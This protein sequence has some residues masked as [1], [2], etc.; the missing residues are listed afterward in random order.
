MDSSFRVIQDDTDERYQVFT[1]ISAINE[2]IQMDNGMGDRRMMGR[3]VGNVS[4]R[5][6]LQED[7]PSLR[8][9]R[10]MR[11]DEH[12]QEMRK[13]LQCIDVFRHVE[14]CPVCSSYF[15]KDIRFC[16]IIIAILIIALIFMVMKK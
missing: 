16:W 10:M 11:E 3:K 12:A 2:N 6:E 1:P 15:K 14:T 13:S 8:P 5:I 4:N 9:R 7:V